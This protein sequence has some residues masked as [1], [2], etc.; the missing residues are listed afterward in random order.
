MAQDLLSAQ[1]HCFEHE[2]VLYNLVAGNAAV[3]AEGWVPRLTVGNTQTRDSQISECVRLLW[4]TCDG[5]DF[6]TLLL[7]VCLL[8]STLGDSEADGMWLTLWWT[9]P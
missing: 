3:G 1:D 8:W 9:S 2:K 6:Q 5:S 4:V 7:R